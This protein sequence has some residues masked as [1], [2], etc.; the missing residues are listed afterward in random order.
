MR[1][2]RDFFDHVLKGVDN[3]VKNWPKVQ[4]E[5]RERNGVA[6]V[7]AENEWPIARTQ[8]T[9][10]YLNA[11][12]GLLQPA[13]VAQTASVSYG[14]AVPELAEAERATFE[15][16]IPPAKWRLSFK[17]SLSGLDNRALRHHLDQVGAIV[18]RAMK[19]AHQPAR[20]N[21]DAV[22]RAC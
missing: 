8:Y 20:G 2:L 5:V 1:R 11:A 9:K 4:I 18:R 14:A 6:S 12:N 21:L 17:C 16:A 13:Q 15:R 19:I 7:R 3:D 22:E 10:L